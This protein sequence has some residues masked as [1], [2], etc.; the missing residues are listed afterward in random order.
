MKRKDFKI[1]D[2]KTY[3]LTQGGGPIPN[4]LIKETNRL[5]T[6]LALNGSDIT[7]K[8]NVELEQTRVLLAENFNA[9][10]KNISF[11]PSVSYAMNALANTFNNTQRILT[12]ED[13]FP[14]SSLPWLHKAY[15]VDFV[16]SNKNGTIDL[17]LVKKNIY[18]D[19][20]ILICSHVMYRTGF[21]QNIKELG[22]ICKEYNLIFI[23]D[24]TQSFGVFPIDVKINAIDIVVFHAYKWMNSCFGIGGMYISSRILKEYTKPFLGYTSV[25]YFG[26]KEHN[27]LDFS[28]KEEASAYEMGISPYL[29][30]LIL[31]FMLKYE[32]KIGQ[33][34]ITK[35]VQKLVAFCI[36]ECTNN[37]IPVLSDFPNENLSSIINI[38]AFG[39]TK[40]MLRKEGIIARSDANKISIG[41]HYYNNKKDIKKLIAVIKKLA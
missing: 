22:A 3:L 9:N 27:T 12:F 39:I 41:I 30:I 17:N 21:K 23:V 5:L 26:D 40:E 15:K 36:Q 11:I 18:S 19:T 10:K 8:W 28:I 34:E 29:N 13:D 37:A 1:F 38:K 20:K 16:P 14:T 24:A 25:N 33:E 7:E 2:K 32:N 4:S 6:E 31:G 35:R